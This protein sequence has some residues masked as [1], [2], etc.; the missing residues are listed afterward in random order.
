MAEDRDTFA[1]RVEDIVKCG[2]V[3]VGFSLGV[4]LGLFEH[5][6]SFGDHT[7]TAQ[8]LAQKASCKPG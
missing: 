3:T 7:F 1:A 6:A 8:D 2:T 4:Q 5:M